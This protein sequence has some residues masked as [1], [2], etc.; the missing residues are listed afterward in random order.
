MDA[1]SQNTGSAKVIATVTTSGVP[2]NDYGSTPT[3]STKVGDTSGGALYDYSSGSAPADVADSFFFLYDKDRTVVDGSPKPG[4][5]A[6]WTNLSD[7]ADSTSAKAAVT[8]AINT[9]GA[10]NVIDISE[11]AWWK[12]A[13]NLWQATSSPNE[14]QGALIPNLTDA[15]GAAANGGWRVHQVTYPEYVYLLRTTT[16][17]D[18]VFLLGGTWCPNTRPVLP[19]INKYAQQND[20]TVINFDTILDGSVAGGGNSGNNPIQSRGPASVGGLPN[21]NPSFIHGDVIS[22]YLNNQKTEYTTALSNAIT[23]YPG[24][25]TGQP[26]AKVARLQVP[27]LFSYKGKE[28]DEPNGG[29]TRQWLYDKGD[30]TYTE[31]MSVWWFTNPQPNQLGVTPANLPRQAPIWTKINNAL[32]TF[33]YQ[34]DPTTLYP[35]SGIDTDAADF[36]VD[37]D[38][39]NVTFTPAT[40]GGTPPA[41]VFVAATTSA[42][43]RSTRRRCRRRCRRSARWAVLRR[44]TP[45]RGPRSSPRSRRRHRTPTRSQ[46]CR[47]SSAPGRLPAAQDAGH[48]HLGHA[49]EP[50]QRGRG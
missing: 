15:D 46:R 12:S 13:N 6:A 34:T 1:Q 21:A 36:L 37:A 48:Q 49:G 30:G 20:A 31:Y 50:G 38:R 23:Y 4:K 40:A 28:G 5:I 27:Y 41:S 19:S 11:F 2:V 33:N 26:L 47:R 16:S 18:L 35:N 32:A 17:K 3:F 7:H 24:G 39:A 42:A 22:Q 45:R 43:S 9:V 44:T 29:I 8:S 14:Y 25:D 10:A